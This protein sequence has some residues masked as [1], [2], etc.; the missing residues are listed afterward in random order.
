MQPDLVVNN[1][2]KTFS[3]G[4]SE[5]HIL[6][7]VSLSLSSGESLAITG[8]SGVG[9]STLLQIIGTLD[10]P[11]SGTVTLFGEDPFAL[12]AQ[13]QASFRNRQIGFVFQDHHLMPALTAIQNVLLPALAAGAS[14]AEQYAR[15]RELLEAVG[16]SERADHLPGELSGGEKQRIAIARSLL[17]KPKLVLADEPTGNLDPVSAKSITEL[18]LNLQKQE[19]FLLIVVTHSLEVAAAMG[20]RL[21]LA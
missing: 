14:T 10:Q 3:S 20:Q 17:L 2:C 12:D 9:K 19:S 8:P 16:L 15:A 6:R 5:L 18:L 1:I 4:R 13:S 7:G 21:M 11:T